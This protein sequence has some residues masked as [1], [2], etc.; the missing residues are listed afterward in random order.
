[1]TLTKRD[2]NRMEQSMWL[3]MSA[4]QKAAIFDRFGVE[5][6]PY[7]WTG[8]DIVTQIQNFIGCGEFVKEAEEGPPCE[9]WLAGQAA[10]IPF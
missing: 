6:E 3:P 9:M 7:G 8:Q 5:P 4:S 10:G 1:M 2:I